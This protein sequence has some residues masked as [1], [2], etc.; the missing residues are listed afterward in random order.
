M[1]R[2]SEYR[3]HTVKLGEYVNKVSNL[4]NKNSIKLN[5][6]TQQLEILFEL[7]SRGDELI[8]IL[9][10][11]S[12]NLQ[13]QINS[14]KESYV[15]Y[16]DEIKKANN[17]LT[18][19]SSLLKSTNALLQ[20][21]QTNAGL[22]ITSAQS[23]ANLAKNTEI[24][25][26]H[27]KQEGKGLAIIA[28]EC[29]AL[30]KRAQRPFRGLS[31]LLRNLQQ[32]SEPVIAEFHRI[33]VLSPRSQ[34]LLM[35]SF[36]SLKTIDEIT[37]SL[38]K[39]IARVEEHSVINSQLKM[40]VS[41]GLNILKN[42]LVLSLSTLDDM[43][44][45]CAQI[46][47]SAQILDTLNN[48][49]SSSNRSISEKSEPLVHHRE[50]QKN[51]CVKR[52]LEFFLDENI[53]FFERLPGGKELPLFP[54]VVYKN[55]VTI[56]NQ[57]NELNISGHELTG[58]EENLGIGSAKVIDLSTQI[59]N[60]FKETQNIYSHLNNLGEVLH[61]K[62]ENID[63]LISTA[64]RIFS[65]IKTLSVFAKIEEGRSIDYNKIIS[66]VVE[67]FVRLELNTEKA[68]SNIVPQIMQLKQYVDRLRQEKIVVHSEEIMHPDYSKIKIFLDDIIRVFREEEEQ[69]KKICE[70]ADKLNEPNVIL[71]EAWE[72]YKN[73]LSQIST[74]T[75][76]FRSLHREEMTESPAVIKG[77]N[78]VSISV[79]ADPLTL[80]PD[81]KTDVNSHRIICNFSVGLFQFGE[82]AEVI[83]GLCEDYTVSKDGT[84]YVFKIR[85]GIRYHNGK[86]LRIEDI[87]DALIK[88]LKGPNSNFFDM[89]TGAKDFANTYDKTSLGIEII[90]TST[91]KIKLQYPFLPILANLATNSADPYLDDDL[92]IGVGP[93]K[94]STW[95]QG[96]RITLVVNDYYFEGRPSIDEL[97]F[98]IIKDEKEGY[99]LFKKG[100][101]SI[102][103]PTGENLHKIKA[104]TPAALYTI[105]ELSI[106]YLCM[107]CQ[108][109][110]FNDKRVRK[111]IAYAIDRK[112]LVDSFLKGYA[113]A[114]D[115][116]FPPSMRVYSHKATAYTFNPRKAKELLR[117]AGFKNG[118]PGIYSLDVHNTPSVITQAEFVKAN[119]LDIGVR[120]E[121][122][123]IPWHS[124]VEK[125]VAGE[126]IL[127]FRGWVSDNG[128]PDNFVY[129]L[130]HS[131]SHGCT[132]N[133]F[134]FSSSEIDQA[135]D[136]ARKIRNVDQRNL[137][138]NKIEE[139][140]LDESP[141]VFLF[142]RLQNIAIQKYI[143]GLKP[144]PLGLMRAKYVY[145]V[146]N[147]CV[148]LSNSY[149]EG[150]KEQV[151]VPHIAYS[152]P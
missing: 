140:I 23:L 44:I 151:D 17:M 65:K 57:I 40:S 113:I 102:Y 43:S 37:A 49:L 116:I 18:R 109:E 131:T 28:K 149:N 7:F 63:N 31:I 4:L 96:K 9:Q 110:P 52:Q 35:E 61:D 146:G 81:K 67:E 108:K 41:E 53:K 99:E 125:T 134:F 90:N 89:I 3:R 46:N 69:V 47:S 123:P 79:P 133:T 137:M 135:I 32:V 148:M 119:L 84:N 88:T 86:V 15:Q 25:A 100:A 6:L 21:I 94:I 142:H 138:Y 34:K 33:I 145:P 112:S 97:H 22:F 129:P 26:H 27:A 60:F 56:T 55:I 95:E 71:Q 11:Y 104:E 152:K 144:H 5:D 127:S 150:Q 38:K 58:Y 105:P 77:K 48:I 45:R 124:L 141:G 73:T 92:P 68:L 54:D 85:K 16:E 72:G 76:S 103:V 2:F 118:L 87:K 70:F 10:N 91:L 36:E 126:S 30:A 24:R 139:K 80:Y 130:F 122:N 19:A 128:D 83:P 74:V 115:G 136:N 64:S 75:S 51:K 62:I 1:V 107:N 50:L 117:E 12:K 8:K 98:V 66:P 78:V 120:I 121:I 59:E 93:F 111:A 143:L 20:N 13:N 147:R 29:L 14:I 39:I 114:A 42:Q 106:R 82:G 132:G 101:L